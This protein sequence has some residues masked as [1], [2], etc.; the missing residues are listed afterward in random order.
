MIHGVFDA[1]Q[2]GIIDNLT[3]CAD[4]KDVSQPLIEDQL[5]WNPGVGASQDHCKGLLAGYKLSPP[6]RGLMGVAGIALRI[7]QVSFH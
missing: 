5:G 7:A 4:D 2:G 6:L 3:R 1:G